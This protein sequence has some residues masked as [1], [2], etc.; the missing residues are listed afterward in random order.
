M[1]LEDWDCFYSNDE[2]N[3]VITRSTTL[4]SPSRPMKSSTSVAYLFRGRPT[5]PSHVI[6]LWNS[7]KALRSAKTRVMDWTE[8]RT[9]S[10]N[11][12]SKSNAGM[13]YT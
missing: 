11:A 5:F 7:F 1:Y 4:S 13:G 3:G 9:L 8:K 12:R 6:K 2:D 10:G